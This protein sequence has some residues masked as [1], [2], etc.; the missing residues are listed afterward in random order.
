MTACWK[1]WVRLLGGTRCGFRGFGGLG[2][3]PDGPQVRDLGEGRQANPALRAVFDSNKIFEAAEQDSASFVFRRHPDC[4][5]GQ[6]GCQFEGQAQLGA[7]VVSDSGEGLVHTLST[8]MNH[9]IVYTLKIISEQDFTVF[10]V[11]T[12]DNSRLLERVSLAQRFCYNHRLGRN[13]GLSRLPLS[14]QGN[15][16]GSEC[17][18]ITPMHVCYASEPSLWGT[19]LWT[20]N[21]GP[22]AGEFGGVRRPGRQFRC[23]PPFCS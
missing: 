15:T 4:L 12:M 14:G 19:S 21:S 16:L 22:E 17:R 6:P 3:S 23:V 1:G 18:Y 8:L 7:R 11:W 9:S 10:E 13:L 5:D 20:R 2:Q